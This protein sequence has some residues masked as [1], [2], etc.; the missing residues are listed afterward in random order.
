MGGKVITSGMGGAAVGAKAVVSLS[1][2]LGFLAL[3][4]AE[5]Q[6]RLKKR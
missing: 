5:R 1:R 4:G 6:S 3:S 2:Y